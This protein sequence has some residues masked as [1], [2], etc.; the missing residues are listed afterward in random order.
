MLLCTGIFDIYTYI[1]IC[2]H[3]FFVHMLIHLYISSDGSRAARVSRARSSGALCGFRFLRITTYTREAGAHATC[4]CKGNCCRHRELCAA[5]HHRSCGKRMRRTGQA[6]HTVVSW[7]ARWALEPNIIWIIDIWPQRE[8]PN[9]RVKQLS[10]GGAASADAG[11]SGSIHKF[12]Y[13]VVVA[14]I[15]TN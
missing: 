9:S 2:T 14:A 8:T 10:H 13:C 1:S 12:E 7:S 4:H 11:V 15:Q 6:E 5:S 3:M